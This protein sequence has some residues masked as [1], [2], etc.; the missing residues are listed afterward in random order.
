MAEDA[1]TIEVV[2]P[3]EFQEQPGDREGDADTG[4]ETQ[5]AAE[6]GDDTQAGEGGG[7][8]TLGGAEGGDDTQTAAEG[9]DAETGGDPP[10]EGRKRDWK[11][12]QIEKLRGR[13]ATAAQELKEAKDRAAAAEALLAAAPEERAGV[14]EEQTRERIRKEESEKVRQEAYYKGINAGLEK[15]DA[16]G[17]VAFKDTWDDRIAQ[18]RDAFR[19]DLVARPDFLEAVTDLPNSAAVYH[20]LAGDPDKFEAML[21]LPPHKMGMELA[22]LSDKLA[23]PAPRQVSRAPAP[24]VPLNRGGGERS[25]EDLANDPN[26]D[27]AEFDRR[28]SAEE[29]KREAA[30]RR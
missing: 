2:I 12:R 20:E 8:D 18:A 21:A 23:K 9:A 7:E 11:D 10:A 22:R 19:E 24:I 13:E 4:G 5:A 15:M 27:M 14:L 3:D 25:L 29:K 1:D 30:G 17:K 26:T 16:A 28:M 6:A